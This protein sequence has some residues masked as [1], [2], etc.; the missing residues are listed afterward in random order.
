MTYTIP[1]RVLLIAAIAWALMWLMVFV[2]DWMS[3]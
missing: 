3:H 2:A 1:Q